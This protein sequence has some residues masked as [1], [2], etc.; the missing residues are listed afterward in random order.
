[1]FLGR[2][3]ASVDKKWRL[4]IPKSIET[5]KYF[6]LKES[7]NGIQILKKMPKVK[8]EDLTVMFRVQVKTNCRVKR[9]TIPEFLRKSNS[10]YFGRKVTIV[11][12]GYLL[13][14]WPRP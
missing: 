4:T 13:E 11:G 12:K 5:S 10:F 9:I 6:Y 7:A 3:N 14:V 1:M 8:K 2:W